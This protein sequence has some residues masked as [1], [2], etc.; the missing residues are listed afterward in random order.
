MLN[1]LFA[2]GIVMAAVG[3]NAPEGSTSSTE[4]DI[5]TYQFCGGIAG[6]QCPDGFECVDNPRDNCDPKK[7]GAD[8]GGICVKRGKPNKCD[9]NE[10]GLHYVGTS[11][12]QCS[13]IKCLCT[14]GTAYFS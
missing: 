2:L 10:P 9:Y 11:L 8:C 1:K 3:C 14:V 7:G 4:D 6:L 13:V 5:K 12:A